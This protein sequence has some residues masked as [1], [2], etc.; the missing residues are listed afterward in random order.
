MV[1]DSLRK[2]EDQNASETYVK[3]IKES[4]VTAFAGMLMRFYNLKLIPHIIVSFS[5]ASETVSHI[6]AITLT[7]ILLTVFLSDL[8]N[9]VYFHLDDATKPGST[10]ARTSRNRL[11]GRFGQAAE[12][13]GQSITALC[14]GCSPRSSSVASRCT[15]KYVSYGLYVVSNGLNMNDTGIPHAATNDDVY[16]GYFI[17]QGATYLRICSL[18]IDTDQGP[19]L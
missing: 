16:N 17:P 2:A 9:Y 18:S 10:S 11:C 5:A 12:F 4:A 19:Q 13:R 7:K 6:A 3:A 14:R 8:I 15:I 1:A